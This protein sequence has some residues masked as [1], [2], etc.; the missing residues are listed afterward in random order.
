M[1]S[2]VSFTGSHWLEMVQDTDL[3]TIEG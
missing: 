3:I 1:L 2:F